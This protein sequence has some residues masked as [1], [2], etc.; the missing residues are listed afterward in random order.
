MSD[1]YWQRFLA[2]QDPPICHGADRWVL[3]RAFMLL[4][5]LWVLV[6]GTILLVKVA[7]WSALR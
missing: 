2:Q 1:D 3:R 7:L 4:G 5:S 6:L